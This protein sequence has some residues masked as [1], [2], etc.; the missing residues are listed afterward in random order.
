MKNPHLIEKQSS[1][2]GIKEGHAHMVDAKPNC[3]GYLVEVTL[4]NSL[5]R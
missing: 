2:E 5:T 3:C 1:V 4:A